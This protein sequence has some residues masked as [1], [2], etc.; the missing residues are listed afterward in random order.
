[1]ADQHVP[2]A[3][4]ATAWPIRY[5]VSCL[6]PDHQAMRHLS[7]WVEW[8]GGD[9][10]AVTD[11]GGRCLDRSGRWSWEPQTSNRGNKWIADHRFGLDLALELAKQAAPHLVVNNLTVADVL[12]G[13]TRG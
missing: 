9:R 6:P 7:V 8:R 3:L 13:R 11:G 5:Q 10:W 2:T 12:A 4:A 1:V